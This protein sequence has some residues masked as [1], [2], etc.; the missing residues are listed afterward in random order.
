MED[1]N[2]MPVIPDKTLTNVDMDKT[3]IPTAANSFIPQTGSAVSSAISAIQDTVAQTTNTLKDKKEDKTEILNV[4]DFLLKGKLYNNLSCLS[5]TSGEAQIFLVNDSN[6]KNLVLKLYYPNYKSKQEIIRVILNFDFEMIVKLY[7]FGQ[8]FVEGKKRDYELMEYLEGNTL[9]DYK[10][11]KDID[12][13]RRIALQCAAALAYCHNYHI[14]HKDIKPSNFFFRDKEQTQVVLGDFGISS[15]GKSTDGQE[16]HRTT[17][18]RTPVFAAPEMYTDV[19]DG[20][21]EITPAADFYSLGI[22]LLT[23]WLGYNPMSNNERTMMRQKSDGKIPHINELPDRVMMIIQGLTS[24][25]PSKRWGYDEVER[26]FNGEN[27]EVSISSPFL[28]Y[29]TFV[30]DPDK[31]L[32]AENIN[33]LVPLLYENQK[34]SMY[35]LYDKRISKWL[36]ECGNTKVSTELDDIVERRY[37]VDQHAGLM[38]A[39][40]TMN[41]KFPYYDLHGN[42]CDDVHS[43]AIA[44]L[45]YQDDYSIILRDPNNLVFVYLECCTQCNVERLRS[46]F[47]GADYNGRVAILRMVYEIDPSIPFLTKYPSSSVKEISQSFGKYKCTDDDWNSLCDG[48]LLSWMFCHCDEAACES[49]RILTSNKECSRSFAYKVLYNI[50]RDSAFDLL[51]ANTPEKIAEQMNL[52][53][54]QCQELSDAEFKEA[55]D[56]FV[57]LDGRFFYFAQLHDW[58]DQVSEGR[59]CFNLLSQD[60]RERLGAYDL[61][62]A[63]YKFCYILGFRPTYLLPDGTILDD[64]NKLNKKE[65]RAFRTEIRNGNFCQWLSLFYHEN[66]KNE[67]VEMYSY[68][69]SLE[70]YVLK[71]G[72]IDIAQPYYKRFLAA[73]E[74]TEKRTENTKSMWKSAATKES[75]S[76]Q[77]FCL[78]SVLWLLLFIFVRISNPKFFMDNIFWTVGV[79]VGICSMAI[80]YGRAYFKGYGVLF[81]ILQ[82]ILG[83]ISVI[84]T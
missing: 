22:T 58:F 44:L 10:L 4:E 78:L 69:R 56:D 38:A 72:E 43:L 26:W 25:N 55:M 49:L 68:E 71:L 82:G 57:N 74:E 83:C 15:L 66:P 41:Q 36:E 11:D 20:I 64:G 59:Q 63:A 13:F 75:R 47:T 35:Y 50:D 52:K 37:P 34:I 84:I 14:I 21:V 65:Y 29:K 2:S 30:V 32:V 16:I 46:Y 77:L 81:S 1:N 67:F 23:L 79:P 17:Q 54:Q 62:T 60:N 53:L 27:V 3:A 8:T 42:P 45:S 9:K 12:N 24:V 18:A 76:K 6:G 73:K 80:V 31:N 19:I 51:D 28:R 40:Y 33:E 61:K 7:D 5:D 70:Q 48:R 39:I